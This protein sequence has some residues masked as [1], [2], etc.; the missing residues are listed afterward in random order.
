MSVVPRRAVAGGSAQQGDI[1]GIHRRTEDWK[2]MTRWLHVQESAK[3][4]ASLIF[5]QV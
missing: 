1:A 3:A 5:V 2:L 4:L